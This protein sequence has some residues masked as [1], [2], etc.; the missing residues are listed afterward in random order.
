MSAVLISIT[1]FVAVGGGA[2]NAVAAEPSYI[3]SAACAPCHRA[4]YERWQRSPHALAM[5]D[6]KSGASLPGVTGSTPVTYGNG[7][8]AT[9]DGKPSVTI[10]ETGVSTGP[11]ETPLVLGGKHITQPLAVFPGGRLQAIPIGYDHEK[12]EWFDIF[13]ASPR[14][15]ED[16]GHWTNR[17]MTANSECIS[18]HVTGFRK[19]YDVREDTYATTYSEGMVGCEACHGPGSRH[20]EVRT[21]HARV[22]SG[23]EVNDHYETVSGERLLAVCASCHALRRELMEQFRP[24]EPLL[25]AFEPVLL[26]EGDYHADGSVAEEAYEWGSFLQSRMHAKGVVCG[27]CHDAH[28]SA[29]KVEGD[30]LCQ[31]CHEEKLKTPHHSRH[32]DEKAQTTCVSC[33]MPESVFMERDRRRDHS[34]SLPDPKRSEIAGVKSPCISCH[35]DKDE[36]WASRYV[37]EWFPATAERRAERESVTEA[38]LAAAAG[39]SKGLGPIVECLTACES[40]IRRATAAKL[41]APFAENAEVRSALLARATDSDDLVRNAAV[42]ALAESRGISDDR[43]AAA[44]L[45]SARDERRSVRINAAWGLRSADPE[46]VPE[47]DRTAVE[48]ASNDLL[49]SLDVRADSAESLFTKGSFLEARHE[50]DRA[51]TE[52]RAALKIAPASIPP[53]Y[54]LAMLLAEGKRLDDAQRELDELL[55]HD[56]RFA[57]GHFAL[58]LVYGEQ[59]EW[60][61]AVRSLTE[62]LKIDPYYP[63]ALH[64]LAHAYFE[65]DQG[66]LANEV[67]EAALKHP[68]ARE[69]ALTTLVSVN[70]ALEDR[71]TAKRWAR[72]A[73][74]EIPGFDRQPTVAALLAE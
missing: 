69:E 70:L 16:W 55:T 46:R 73:A 21:E 28:T 14:T 8:Q 23:G 6:V 57:P 51:M 42:W 7:A 2:K 58:G 34:F 72:E 43:V 63:G 54:R 49:S 39:D 4:E 44:L 68:R 25:D 60:R 32:N 59:G 26:Q 27:D 71:E 50:P 41:L 47:G 5:R 19:G 53:R 29:L 62:C 11:Y 52:Y 61:E 20:V 33:H 10:A 22:A 15:A 35:S 3:G 40:P 37:E 18:C 36:A 65:L 31:S 74:R 9:L 17:G 45:T 48:R 30:A 38:F 67:L 66:K 56:P 1:A 64:N 24:G 13:A 12:A